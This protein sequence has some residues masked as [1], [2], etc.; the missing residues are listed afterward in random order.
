MEITHVIRRGKITYRHSP[1]YAPFSTALSDISEQ[2]SI[3]SGI[4]PGRAG[5]GRSERTYLTKSDGQN[6]EFVSTASRRIGLTSGFCSPFRSGSSSATIRE[7]Q[8]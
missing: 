1:G 4:W 5:N 3:P 7:R 2:S 8:Q 6:G